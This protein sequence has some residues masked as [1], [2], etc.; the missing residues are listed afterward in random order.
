L[1][2][3]AI[4]QMQQQYDEAQALNAQYQEAISLSD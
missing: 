4:A 3:Q 1:Q 2:Q